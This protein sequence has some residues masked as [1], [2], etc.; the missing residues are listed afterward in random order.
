MVP[1]RASPGCVDT[2][3]VLAVS[4]ELDGSA[5]LTD[6]DI[7]F[8]RDHRA[9]ANLNPASPFEGAPNPSAGFLASLLSA[10]GT[11]LSTAA[12]K[13][14]ILG[15]GNTGPGSGVRVDLTL[16]LV[17]GATTLEVE[18]RDSGRVLIDL[19]LRGHLQ[20]LCLDE[21]CLS[22]CRAPDAG[23]PSPWTAIDAGVLAGGVM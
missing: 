17:P 15:L 16:S 11:P 9:V 20:L 21:P 13:Y 6:L 12:F 19:D 10:D 14:P 2:P 7:S 4:L 8:R 5:S 22:V 1:G 23:A 18:N 3:I